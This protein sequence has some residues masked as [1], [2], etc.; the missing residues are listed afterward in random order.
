MN[1]TIVYGVIQT[2]AIVQGSSLDFFLYRTF[3]LEFGVREL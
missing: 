1:Q 3:D 2:L